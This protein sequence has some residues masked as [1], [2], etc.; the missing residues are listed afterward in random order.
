ME[1]IMCS[2]WF[3]SLVLSFLHVEVFVFLLFSLFCED[4]TLVMLNA[5]YS[6]HANTYNMLILDM[7][8]SS[9]SAWNHFPFMN[10]L[11]SVRKVCTRKKYFCLR[12]IRPIPI[13]PRDRWCQYSMLP[14][15]SYFKLLY[16]IYSRVS[17]LLLFIIIPQRCFTDDRKLIEKVLC[18]LRNCCFLKAIIF[19]CINVLLIHKRCRTNT[20]R[21][22]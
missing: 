18:V 17:A 15:H 5:T 7:I 8:R 14:T 19:I 1:K 2:R 20:E 11:Y 4:T 22:L 21:H 6:R 3:R 13:I 10:H 12:F 16:V 9:S